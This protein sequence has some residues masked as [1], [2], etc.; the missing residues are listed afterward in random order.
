MHP[1]CGLIG[2]DYVLMPRRYGCEARNAATPTTEVLVGGSG[3]HVSMGGGGQGAKA[4]RGPSETGRSLSEPPH[5]LV[6]ASSLHHALQNTAL[7]FWAV[8]VR[9]EQHLPPVGHR[10]LRVSG[11]RVHDVLP[12]L[13]DPAVSARC[14]FLCLL[15][16]IVPCFMLRDVEPCFCK[17]GIGEASQAMAS[18]ST[19]ITVRQG[20]SERKVAE[21]EPPC[22]INAHRNSRYR[23][24]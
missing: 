14:F 1:W 9:L 24:V 16:W 11:H 12:R 10:E 20:D 2:G 23:P 8:V 18:K 7:S 3:V 5:G 22:A 13:P 17:C 15:F 21:A 6:G 19:Q 4:A